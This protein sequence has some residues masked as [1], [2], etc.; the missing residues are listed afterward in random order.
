MK[1]ADRKSIDPRPVGARRFMMLTRNY[2]TTN[3]SEECPQA[4]DALLLEPFL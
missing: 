1:T 4:D 2:L 3:Q